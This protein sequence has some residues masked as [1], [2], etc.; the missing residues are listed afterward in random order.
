MQQVIIKKSSFYAGVI[1]LGFSLFTFLMASQHNSI[2]KQSSEAIIFKPTITI[3]SEPN[4]NSEALFTL[5]EGTKVTLLETSNDL[6]LLHF[7][8]TDTLCDCLKRS[9]GFDLISSIFI[10]LLA[11]FAIS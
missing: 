8:F 3:Q 9:L 1:F 10:K 2:I 4:S 11:L 6:F 5:H 7:L